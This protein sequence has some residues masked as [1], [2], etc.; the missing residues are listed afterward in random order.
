MKAAK[1]DL[2]VLW[3]KICLESDMNAFEQLYRFL[4]SRLIKFSI[5][6]VGDKQA[7]EDLVTEV[8][9]KCWENRSASTHV[10]NPESYFF[11]AVKNQSL[12][13]LKKKSSVTFMDLADVDE[14][15]S[16]TAQTP[17]YIL[18]TKELHQQ[19]H[20]AIESLAPQ[21]REV[22]RLIKE[23]GLK[24]KEV[25]EL[26]N[27][28]PRTV[29]TQL[30]RAIAKLRLILKPLAEMESGETPSGTIIS[31]LMLLGSLSF[32]SYL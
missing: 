15:I 9:V 29:Q 22:F 5:Y 19:L 26:L 2:V 12:K 24:Y 13:H 28:S 32:L 27:I 17:Q 8:F 7:A 20:L 16:A 4:Y 6:Y 11:I 25:A 14:D 23:G 1:P 18:E 21:A 30:F 10:L 3:S 31:L